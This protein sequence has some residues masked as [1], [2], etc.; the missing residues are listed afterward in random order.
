MLAENEDPAAESSDNLR[1]V[2]GPAV[3]Q[4]VLDD[5]VSV[6][7]L[8]EALGV[9]V[10]LLQYGRGLLPRAVLQDTLDDA[11]AV[12]VGGQGEHLQWRTELG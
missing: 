1:L 6:L 5:V 7:V 12:R 11:T 10:E 9:R 8:H 2:L 4:H 3:L